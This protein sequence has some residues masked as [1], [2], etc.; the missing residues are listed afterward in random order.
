[1]NWLPCRKCGKVEH[2]SK[3]VEIRM[4]YPDT[5]GMPI[6]FQ[7]CESCADEIKA[8]IKNAPH[9]KIKEESK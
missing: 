3:I 9:Y 8:K 7:L 4:I 6:D 1:M 2:I 5:S